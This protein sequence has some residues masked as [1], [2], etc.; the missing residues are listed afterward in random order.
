MASAELNRQRRLKA[1]A[2]STS[3]AGPKPRGQGPV[4]WAALLAVIGSAGAHAQGTTPGAQPDLAYT[5]VSGLDGALHPAAPHEGA[6][7]TG[8]LQIRKDLPALGD[9]ASSRVDR[10]IVELDRNHVPADGQSAIKVTMRVLGKDGKP[11][12]DTVFATIEH[13]GGRVLLPKARTDEFGPRAQDADRVNP[14]VQLAVRNGVAEFHLLAPPDAQDV[15]L[16]ITADGQQASG[17]VSFVPDLRPMIA[18]GLLEGVVSFRNKVSLTPTRRG[19]GFEQEIENWSREFNDGKANA[20]ARAAFYLKGTSS[21][22]MLLTAAYDSDKVTHARLLRDVRA[23]ELYPVYGD[24]SLKS[25]DARSGSRLYVRIDKHKSYVM[26]GDF[27]TGDGFSQPAGQGAVA[28]LKQR[29]LGQY[30]RTATGIRGHHETDSLV[31]NAFAFNDT[32]RS[33]VEEFSSQGSGPYALRHN[34]VLEGSEKIEV[35]VR[36]RTQPSRIVSVRPLTRLIDYSFEP[37]SGRILLSTFLPSVDE[38]LN[39]VTLRVTY[40]VDQGGEAHWV[41]GADAQIKL[42]KSLEIGGSVVSDRNR[43]APYDLVSGNLTLKFDERSAMVVELAQSTSTVNTNPANLNTSRGLSGRSGEVEGRAARLEFVHQG[44]NTEARVF[45]GR[46]SPLFNNPSA[47]LAGGR[48]EFYGRSA[49]KVAEGWKVYGEASHSEDRNTGGGERQTAA[50]GLQWMPDNRLLLDLSVRRARETVGTH[51]TAVVISP[52]SL[53]GGLTGSMATGSGGGAVGFG[54]QAVDPVT[55]LP[56]ITQGSLQPGTSSLAAGTRLDST[57]VRLG[58]GYRVTDK[59]RV[60]G[61][62][63]A[64]VD[65]D[66]RRRVALGADYALN[67]K[68]RLYG[69]AEHQT[70]WVMLNGVSDTRRSADTFA[71]GIDANVL[72]ETQLFSEYRLRDAI[73][74]RDAQIASGARHFWDV[75]EGLR[76]HVALERIKVLSGDTSTVNAMAVGVDYAAHPLWR[77]ST[78]VE[79]RRSGDLSST[80]GIDERFSTTLWT[81]MAARK[82]D[83][84]WTLLA[85]NHMLGTDYA[86]RGDVFQNRAQ[87]GV[88]YRP[89]DTNV[90]NALGKIEFKHESDASNA[91]VGTLRTRGVIVSAHADVHP[92]RAWWMTGRVAA[93][94]QNDQFEGGLRSNFRAQL[95]SGRVVYDITE[96]W[97]IG[98]MAAVQMGQNGARQHAVGAE[99]GYL[100]RQNLWLSA[101]FNATGFAGDTDLAGYEYTRSGFYIRLRF[102]FDENL[103]KGRDREVNRSLDR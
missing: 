73:S 9:Q 52:F 103:F 50:L 57:S 71:L 94:W 85:R 3:T 99:V 69:R 93:K 95:V 23:D 84:D 29:S 68:A 74:G 49:V 40:E 65:G 17:A 14:G 28:S 47:P 78:R 41:A 61:E 59:L 80:P 91:A 101:G 21:G 26:F 77:G 19:D 36:D 20:A 32:L 102:K 88:A 62:I 66:E 87:L 42:N 72:R 34:A 8:S 75:A 16:R 48:D 45:L 7:A 31:V 2:T 58:A 46:S 44:D 63:E 90:V 38:N 1:A 18:A 10:I 79:H 4:A 82:L 12:N 100:L 86:A 54:V 39:P 35:V 81:L 76:A 15:R 70:G 51:S 56:M 27:V 55:G 97:D 98:A 43:L 13:S 53:T 30:N 96:N 37:F 89:T 33:T 22:E 5:P 11:L 6:A 67:S 83:R 60:G 25:F 64:D 92:S 24:A